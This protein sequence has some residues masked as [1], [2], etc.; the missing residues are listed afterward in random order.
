MNST[1]RPLLTILLLVGLTCA[2]TGGLLAKSKSGGLSAKSLSEMVKT[3][4]GHS[5]LRCDLGNLS[6]KCLGIRTAP[7]K[8]K[9]KSRVLGMQKQ[10]QRHCSGLPKGFADGVNGPATRQALVKFQK[11]YGLQ[12]DGVYGPKTAHALAKNPNGRC[13]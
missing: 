5:R 10:L 11:A 9:S 8:S 3:K 2:P 1:Q 13:K 12:P 6:S 7:S 4:A